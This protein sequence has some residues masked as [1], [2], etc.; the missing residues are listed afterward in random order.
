M[1]VDETKMRGDIEEIQQDMQNRSSSQTKTEN[2]EKIS[3]RALQIINNI[4]PNRYFCH[5]RFRS[6][7]VMKY[8]APTH[9]ICF[10]SGR[11]IPTVDRNVI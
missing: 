6:N 7:I 2:D 11:C 3:L 8:K 1:R 4:R 10:C 5:K 9:S